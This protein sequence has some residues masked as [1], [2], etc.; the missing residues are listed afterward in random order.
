MKKSLRTSLIVAAVAAIVSL[1]AL[2][3]FWCDGENGEQ[4]PFFDDEA[5]HADISAHSGFTSVEKD[6]HGMEYTVIEFSNIAEA[7]DKEDLPIE[8]NIHFYDDAPWMPDWGYYAGQRLVEKTKTERTEYHDEVYIRN[9][10]CYLYDMDDGK[11]EENV[12]AYMRIL[13]Q[14]GY[15]LIGLG[16]DRVIYQKEEQY[17]M[18][19]QIHGCV[20]NQ[21]SL[22]TADGAFGL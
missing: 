4:T 2:F 5:T 6:H 17:I 20:T 12:A 22:N 7:V 3:F 8:N 16:E 13:R 11:P 9:N 1:A 10:I 15:E 21:I 19:T 14:A 18:L